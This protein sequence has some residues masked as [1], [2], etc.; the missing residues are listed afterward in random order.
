[1]YR[2]ETTRGTWYTLDDEGYVL[3]RTDGPQGWDYRKGWRILGAA[4]RYHSR[5]VTPLA[6]A[7][8][9]GIP[10]WGVIHDWDHGHHRV[11]GGER[12]RSL[13]KVTA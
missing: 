3:G 1:M 10:G 5:R 4:T 11:W 13:Y 2:M 7:A 6:D 12:M 8:A 9:N